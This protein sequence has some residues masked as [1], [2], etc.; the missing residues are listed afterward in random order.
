MSTAVTNGKAPAIAAPVETPAPVEAPE[1]DVD[2][3]TAA[4]ASREPN[5]RVPDGARR[6]PFGDYELT[7]GVATKGPSKGEAHFVLVNGSQSTGFLQSA[8]AVLIRDGLVPRDTIR[9]LWAAAD[10]RD[11]A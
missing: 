10:K 9:A 3:L 6:V 2:A 5:Y 8:V 7:R 1:I 11:S 4:P